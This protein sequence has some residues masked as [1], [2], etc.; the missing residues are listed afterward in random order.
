[1]QG[2]GAAAETGLVETGLVGAARRGGMRRAGNGTNPRQG[3]PTMAEESEIL[4]YPAFSRDPAAGNP[5]GVV[6]DASGLDAPQMQRIA[7]EVGF[8]ETAF[9]VPDAADPRQLTVR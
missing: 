3:L 8:S 4:R 6:P 7:A 5:A 1:E 2:A 9:L